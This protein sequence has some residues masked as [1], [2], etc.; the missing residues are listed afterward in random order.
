MQR[1]ELLCVTLAAACA[2]PCVGCGE[3]SD[4]PPTAT[5]T[6]TVTYQGQPVANAQITFYPDEGRKPA[7]G[8]ADEDG[9]YSLTT[10]SNGDG[11]IPGTHKVTVSATILPTWA[12]R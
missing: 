11:A 6:G 8:T 1:I 4:L 5:V 2:L 10:F 7:S 3:S 9:A 12:L